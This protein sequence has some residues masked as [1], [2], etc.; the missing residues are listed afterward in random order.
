M[1]YILQFAK[2]KLPNC[3]TGA[4]SIETAWQRIYLSCKQCPYLQ[5]CLK[6]GEKKL[7]S[8]SGGILKYSSAVF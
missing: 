4:L 1:K 5:K 8:F 7:L 6:E 2:M 3:G